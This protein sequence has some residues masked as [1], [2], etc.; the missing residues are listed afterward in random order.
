MPTG[1]P[2]YTLGTDIV[3]QT[4]GDLNIDVAAQ[5]VGNLLMDIA[6]QSVGNLDI[7]VAAQTIGNLSVDLVAQSVGTLDIDVVAQTIGNMQVDIAAASIT[8]LDVDIEAQT[9]GNLAIDISAQTVD[10]MYI[11][12]QAP[13]GATTIFKSGTAASSTVILH[14]VTAGKTFYLTY[15]NLCCWGGS[16]ERWG[17]IA[18]RNDSDA[19]QYYLTQ[20][21]TKGGTVDAGG[22]S[23][24][25]ATI[26]IVINPALVI[27]AGWDIVVIS[28]GSAHDA[29]GA[30]GGWEA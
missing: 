2:D 13:S 25:T 4:L 24:V 26:P 18:V 29:S 15:A 28:S 22:E 7:D 8:A 16:N 6:A 5:S 3:A 30:V 10:R 1:R 21:K 9:I 14:T 11:L 19:I 17:R 20:I 23:P 27:A 12:P